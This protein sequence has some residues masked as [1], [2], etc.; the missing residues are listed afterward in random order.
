MA[1]TVKPQVAEEDIRAKILHILSIYPVISPT[2]LQAGLG[3]GWRPKMWHPVLDTLIEEGVIIRE[4][5]SLMTPS[6]RYNT[7][8]ILRLAGVDVINGDVVEQ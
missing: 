3:G 4:K 7:H 1:K 6:N 2:M 8:P 5:K